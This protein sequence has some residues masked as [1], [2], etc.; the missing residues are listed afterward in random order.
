MK[1]KLTAK[2]SKGDVVVALYEV[3]FHYIAVELFLKA[4]HKSWVWNAGVKQ[5][6]NSFLFA[7]HRGKLFTQNY[8]TAMLKVEEVEGK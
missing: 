2:F 3:A 8:Q 5:S 7:A 1:L 6:D 4:N